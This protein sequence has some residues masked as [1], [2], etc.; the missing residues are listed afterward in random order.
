MNDSQVLLA[1]IGILSLIITGLIAFWKSENVRKDEF[2]KSEI[3]NL[4]D[5]I[6]K[7]EKWKMEAQEEHY[8]TQR[9]LDR[10]IDYSRGF[11]RETR[12]LLAVIKR[13]V[14]PAK[15]HIDKIESW[16]TID[17]VLREFD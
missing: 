3:D 10:V 12:D 16:P 17:D 6:N 2:W 13:G 11:W 1:A 9:K 5:R 7:L 15:E 14:T 8:Q 4:S